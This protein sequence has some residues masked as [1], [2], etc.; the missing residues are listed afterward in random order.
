[1]SMSMFRLPSAVD[2]DESEDPP[3][4][5]SWPDLDFA[6]ELGEQVTK[7]LAPLLPA[8]PAHFVD[9]DSTALNDL[10]ALVQEGVKEGQHALVHV[11]S[12]GF[13]L[14][15]SQQDLH[16]V[17]KDTL[18]PDEGDVTRKA[19]DVRQFLKGLHGHPGS[20][21]LLL[22]VCH[23]GAGIDWTRNIEYGERRVFVIAACPPHTQA[24]GGRFSQAVSD[25][26]ERLAQGHSGIDTTEKYVRLTWFKEEVHRRVLRLC[27]EEKAPVQ[28]V[29][30]SE[31]TAPNIPFLPNR[32]FREDP[33]EVFEL[34][35]Y[36]ALQDFIGSVHPSLDVDHYVSR[37]AGRDISETPRTACHF[38]GR[39]EEL[40]RVGDWLEAGAEGGGTLCVVTGSPGVGKS[41]LLGVVVCCIHPQLSKVLQ[42]NFSQGAARALRPEPREWIAAVHARG[43]TLGLVL[44]AIA[45]QLGLQ[46]PA[47]GWSAQGLVDAV[48][49]LSEEPLI[50][51]DALD[52]ATES[53]Q[54]AVEL[55][56]PLANREYPDSPRRRACQLLVGVRPY[57]DKLPQMAQAVEDADQILIDLDTSHRGRLESALAEY[58]E[59][60]LGDTD[61]YRTRRPLR[62]AIAR[63][64]AHRVETATVG[65]EFLKAQLSARLIAKAGP[66]TEVDVESALAR[67]PLTFAA[68]LEAQLDDER[69]H[70]LARAVLAALAFSAGNGM[71]ANLIRDVVAASQPEGAQPTVE[72]IESVLTLMSF[73]LRRDVDPVYG[74]TLYR[75]F[76]QELVDRLRQFPRSVD[77]GGAS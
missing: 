7:N 41:A 70:P 57:W 50:V 15:G 58:V 35:S 55:L 76:H 33:A 72:D 74:T 62:R 18:R 39:E 8:L 27:E 21:L 37:A 6:T 23:G 20:L 36:W 66:L 42:R 1:M 30:S 43:M 22:D 54:I 63:G 13:L 2:D 3:E 68:L 51:V 9:L 71:P 28:E 10:T 24:W 77:T 75:L 25:V 45:A 49:G 19:L 48:A 53:E 14:S 31:L 61:T 34:K 11:L 65:G 4:R 69:T 38:S 67:L 40:E 56:L 32:W 73:Y 17:A 29:I 16:V 26:L 60:L 5:S 64:V 12:H 47:E 44:D 46:P 59:L 52:E